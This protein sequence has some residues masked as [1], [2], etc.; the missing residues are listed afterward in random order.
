[1]YCE[2]FRDDLYK[3]MAC[4]MAKIA[5]RRN[6]W[7]IVEYDAIKDATMEFVNNLRK[8]TE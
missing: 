7:H 4:R 8:R 6:I 1:M 3:H 5:S 2:L